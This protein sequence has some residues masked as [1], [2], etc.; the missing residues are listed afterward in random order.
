MSNSIRGGLA[1]SSGIGTEEGP[2]EVEYLKSLPPCH[3]H[4]VE[5]IVTQ[6]KSQGLFDEFRKTCLADI[7][8][9]GY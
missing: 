5:A 1:T 9:K 2:F 7:D 8:T 3:P 6:I 4:L